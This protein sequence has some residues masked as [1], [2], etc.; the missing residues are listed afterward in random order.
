MGKRINSLQEQTSIGNDMWLLISGS[1]GDYKISPKTMQEL[2]NMAK[3]FGAGE[4]IPQNADLNNY[5]DIGRYYSP[6]AAVSNTIVNTPYKTGGFELIVAQIGTAGKVQIMITM[7]NTTRIFAHVYVDYNWTEWMTLSGD[8]STNGFKVGSYNKTEDLLYKATEVSMTNF[9]KSDSFQDVYV[10]LGTSPG[11]I[12]Q[13]DFTITNGKYTYTLPYFP[14][15]SGEAETFFWNVE[16][17]KVTFRNKAA[18]G[19]DYTMTIGIW[20]T[21]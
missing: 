6:T 9:V 11:K 18:W 8:R 14:F 20:Y 12:I 15:G 1:N 17:S 7:S 5:T 19:S 13:F 21:R 16:G 4:E 3:L 2:A 10:D